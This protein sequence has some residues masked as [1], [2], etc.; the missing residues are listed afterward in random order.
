MKDKAPHNSQWVIV[1]FTRPIMWTRNDDEVWAFSPKRRYILNANQ[2][3]NLGDYI[4][5][6]SD[7]RTS[8]HYKPLMAGQ[9]HL[10]GSSILI[11]RYR[12]RGI[13]DMLFLTGPMNYL[14]FL[15]GGSVSIDAYA[16]A[17]RGV[18]L[19]NHPA[20]QHKATLAGP[21]HYDDLQHYDYHWFVDTAT[22]YDEEQDQL[23]VYDALYK[24]MGLDPAS[25]PA[26]YKRPNIV[27]EDADIKNLDQFLYFTWLEK[28]LDLRKSGYYVVAPLA[29]GSLRA[30]SYQ[31]WLDVINQLKIRRPVVVVGSLDGRVPTT[32]MEAG[33]FNQHINQ[34]GSNVVNAMRNPAMPLRVLASIIS[35][36]TAVGCLDSGPLYVAQSLRVPAVSVWGPHDPGVRIG[37]DPDYMNMAVWHQG[38]CRR[39]PCYSYDRFPHEKCPNGSDQRICEP[40]RTVDP[41]AVLA[42]FEEIESRNTPVTLTKPQ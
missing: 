14:K 23:N 18:I 38:A 36:A 19:A 4:H 10:A 30:A 11:E 42:K 34:A 27:M 41:K 16:L 21:L 8:A 33:E 17:D 29:R 5:T 35:R 2:L 9:A 40:L 37:Y 15:S 12:E 28:K 25:V 20:L 6:I 13:G 1:T 31:M 3:G 24:T 26:E 32:D 39:C 7:L 22:E